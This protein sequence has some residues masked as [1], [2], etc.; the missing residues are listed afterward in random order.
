MNEKRKIRV[1]IA[2]DEE[3]LREIVKSVCES[4]NCDVVGEASNGQEAVDLYR[5]LKPQLTLLDINM[6]GMD[7][8]AALKA[9]KD[10][11]PEAIIVMISSLTDMDLVK[12]CLEAGAA[13]YISKD[14]SLNEIRRDLKK[15]WDEFKSQSGK[16]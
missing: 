3:H 15:T 1:L 7:G 6:P 5:S 16:K 14:S 8:K 13:N 9:I 10:E 11:F 2:D 4:L 12:A